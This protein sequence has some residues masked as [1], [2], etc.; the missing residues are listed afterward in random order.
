MSEKQKTLKNESSTNLTNLIINGKTY[1]VKELT[2]VF[3]YNVLMLIDD[4]ETLLKYYY[5]AIES[6]VKR[7]RD[8]VDSVIE[9]K[10]YR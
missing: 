5:M 3:N 1:S 4:K 10:F 2:S 6:G 8:V 9:R 7:F